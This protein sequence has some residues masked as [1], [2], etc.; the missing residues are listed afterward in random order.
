[1]HDSDSLRRFDFEHMPI[2]GLLI[3][4]DTSWR[5][6]LEHQ[7][8]PEV[9]LNALGEAVGASVLLAATVKF[10]GQ[11]TLQMKGDGPMHLLLTQCT[12][13]LGVRALARYQPDADNLNA[14]IRQLVGVGNLTVTIESDDLKQRY[15]GIVPVNGEHIAQCLE[16]YFEQSEQLPTR[17]WLYADQQGVAGMLLQR[18]PAPQLLDDA[19]ADPADAEVLRN[20]QLR[21][22][23]DWQRVQLIADTLAPAELRELADRDILRRLFNQDDLRLFD[24]APVFFK[25][26]CSRER[27][28]GMLHSLGEAEVQSVLAEQGH[29]EVQCDFCNRAY[30]FDVVDVAQLFNA[31]SAAAMDHRRH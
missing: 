6:L 4:M 14:D 26:R 24:S 21:L 11:L 13:G 20:Q 2:R 12:A 17:L 9:I 27:V 5:A 29:V 10:D 23:D 7:N 1:M 18:L 16:T 8:Y 3:H 30:R 19:A 22:D 31:G 25:C 28:S 15:Q